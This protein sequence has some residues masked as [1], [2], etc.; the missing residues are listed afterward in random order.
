MMIEDEELR[1]LYRISGEERLQRLE[2]DLVQ[3]EENPE[4]EAILRSLRREIHSLKGDSRSLGLDLVASLA[5]RIEDIFKSLRQSN[6]VVTPA[7]SN[8]L[9]TGLNAIERLIGEAVTGESSGVDMEEVFAVLAAAIAPPSSVSS[10]AFPPEPAHSMPL[11]STVVTTAFIEDDEL[12]EIYRTTS[13]ERLQKLEV[14]LAQLEQQ[15][16]DEMVLTNVLRQL[17][18]LKGDSRSVGLET[19]E[20]LSHELE[21]I[22]KQVRSQEIKF[23]STVSNGI[24]MGLTTLKQFVHESVTGEPS[25]VDLNQ[26]L[27]FLAETI[28]ASAQPVAEVAE[29]AR[30]AEPT[31]VAEVAEVTEATKVAEPTKIATTSPVNSS[32]V[33]SPDG[34]GVNASGAS[35]SG[36]SA[37]GAI[38]TELREIYRITSAERIQKLEAGLVHLENHPNDTAILAELMREAHSLK[39]DSSSVGVETIETLTHQFEEVLGY[40]QHQEIA[41]TPPISDRLYDS[42]DAIQQ[43]LRETITGEPSGV[44]TAQVLAHLV[45]AVALPV[46]TSTQPAEP[47]PA[48]SAPQVALPAPSAA[49]ETPQIETIRIQTRDL[50]A[51]MAQ[52]DELT[53]TKI[54]TAQ[55][56]AQA[57]QI[58]LLWQDW[59]TNRNRS[60][61][62]GMSALTSPDEER[63]EQLINTLRITAQENQSK[64]DRIVGTLG[65][66][67][68]TLRLLPLSTV[69]QSFPR[70]VRDL[71]KQQSKSIQLSI[72]GGEITADKQVLE[73]IKDALTHLIRNAIDH[74]IETPE[75][76][77][78]HQKPSTATI[79][80]RG[81]KTENSIVIEV[82][83][84]GRGLD[85]EQI[86][87]TAIRR[88]LYRADELASMSISQLQNLILAP[89]FS[90]RTLITEVSGRG[91]G[92]D[93]V[94]TVVE[95]M[96]GRI[97]IESTPGQGCTFRLQLST[98][99]ATLNVVLVDVQGILYALPFEALQSTLLVSPEQLTTADNRNTILVNGQSIPVANLVDVLELSR[100]PAYAAIAQTELRQRDRRICILLN[101][102]DQQ[103]GLFVDR[104]LDTQEVVIKPQSQLLKRVRNVIGA[105]TLADGEVCMILN[106]L[107]LVQSLQ[108]P[109][110]STVPIRPRPKPRR[111]PVILLVED[112][113]PVRIQEKRLFESAGYEVVSA[114]DGLDGYNILRSRS[115][116]AV[117][118]D[119]EMP[120]LSRS[121]IHSREGK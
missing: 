8:G 68:R 50:D 2:A 29:V 119:I 98:S 85:L 32:S 110:G 54:Q 58:A 92:L 23:T 52:A 38:D 61:R 63:L 69:F 117:V 107:E 3:L 97:Q 44:N 114:V 47:T 67:I 11:T 76:R 14:D 93:V 86:K 6:S 1:D 26:I 30:V 74:G 82:A 59:K 87:Q 4:N 56:M 20:V 39:G 64:L 111:Q 104:L 24:L 106:P 91:V 15:P 94:R 101:V 9:F 109:T 27:S 89:G 60:P 72:E 78:Q 40:I 45:E 31:E 5:Q 42:L 10:A 53:V 41:L 25:G 34:F 17:H 62:L 102:E 70:L 118:S 18:S 73:G 12:R 43:L 77:K 22:V 7:M 116:D 33:V 46:P 48:R 55:M 95:R 83:D 115:F 13:E 84:D 19:V 37:S 79:V 49:D 88:K 66:T 121:Q 113:P 80:L 100:S 35:A 90:T 112:S 108:Q 81:Y 103:A 120:N 21:T 36:A 28:A 57:E 65:E 105:T 51:L 75:E 71:A 99:L 96:K 16:T